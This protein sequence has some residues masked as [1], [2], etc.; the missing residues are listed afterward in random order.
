MQQGCNYS[1]TS[2]KKLESLEKTCHPCISNFFYSFHLPG[3]SS[4]HPP[5]S[6]SSQIFYKFLLHQLSKHAHHAAYNDNSNGSCVNGGSGTH[7]K[8]TNTQKLILAT[9]ITPKTSKQMAPT[10]NSDPTEPG[11][12]S[13]PQTWGVWLT[14]RTCWRSE[15]GLE[16]HSLCL[17][18]VSMWLMPA[19]KT[20]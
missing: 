3:H 14:A 8:Q 17:K 10:V 16:G 7:K 6:F 9:G 4:P 15:T 19:S 11:K 5:L 20:L 1:C 2:W 18:K 13:G 12:V